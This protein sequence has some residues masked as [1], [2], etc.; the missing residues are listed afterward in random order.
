[1]AS[2]PDTPVT[3]LAR[4]AVQRTCESEASWERLFALYEPVIRK[5]AKSLGAGCDDEDVAQE[6]FIKLV[7]VLRNGRYS[8]SA[9]KFRSYLMTLIRNELIGR[10]RKAQVRKSTDHV[11][12]D[13]EDSAL[14]ISVPESV[15]AEIDA[16]WYQAR[17]EAAVDHALTK[18][19]MSRQSK[20]VYRMYVL[21]ERPVAEVMKKFGLTRNTVYQI[22]TRVE[23]MIAAIEDELGD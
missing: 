1:M 22:K 7:D 19:F 11:S 6:I 20:D 13:D 8:P 2:F 5:C 10:W 17:H 23:K 15:S 4:I 21:E 12:I 3:M 9:G 14:V 16:K 18:T